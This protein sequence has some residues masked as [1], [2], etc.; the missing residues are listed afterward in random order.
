MEPPRIQQFP[1]LSCLVAAGQHL[2]R[3][4]PGSRDFAGSA[5]PGSRTRLRARP[6]GDKLS[7]AEN[8]PAPGAETAATGRTR[9]RVSGR[10][11][12]RSRDGRASPEVPHARARSGPNRH[13]TARRLGPG[14]ARGDPRGARRRAR[15]RLLA[16]A[17]AP[18]P[19]PDRRDRGGLQR[20]R[21]HERQD[22]EGARPHAPRDRTRGAHGPARV[23]R[24]RRRRLGGERRV[25]QRADRRPR[26][27]D[28]R[29]GARAR[30][31]LP[32]ATST[33]RWPSR[34]RVSR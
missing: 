8:P 15:R 1:P 31:R 30:R 7:R 18:P 25:A 24:P 32:T 22:G 14:R 33:A 21:V 3:T 12:D 9:R 10:F 11:Q 17:L 6:P 23:A 5:A 16:P 19:R 29:G 13:R 4:A 20:A 34:S 26:P 2:G 28:H 27:P